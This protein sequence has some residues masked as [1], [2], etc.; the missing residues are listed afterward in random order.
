VDTSLIVFVIGTA[1]GFVPMYWLAS[2][3][4]GRRRTPA[5]VGAKLS[6]GGGDPAGRGEFM[7]LL[8]REAAS[9]AVAV[10]RDALIEARLAAHETFGDRLA[11]SARTRQSLDET[12]R[13]VD[14]LFPNELREAFGRGLETLASATSES[15]GTATATTAAV[16]AAFE[17]AL[18][19]GPARSARAASNRGFWASIRE[20]GRG[21]IGAGDVG[22]TA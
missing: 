17:Q 14:S 22:V 6:L 3:L 5:K 9:R 11:L 12:R 18:E 7:Q 15:I 4:M 10:L 1:A 19:D 13:L 20:K 21:W 16:I 8:R 2:R